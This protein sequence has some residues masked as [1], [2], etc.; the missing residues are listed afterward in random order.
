MSETEAETSPLP[1]GGTVRPI[2]RWGE[3]VMHRVQEPVTEFDDDLRALAADMVATMYAADG[4]GLVGSDVPALLAH[5]RDVIPLDNRQVAEVRAGSVRLFDFE[6]NEVEPRTVTI[7]WDLEAAEKGGFED[8]MLKEI[9]EQPE[10]VR[11]TMLGRIDSNGRVTLD[12]VHWTNGE[13]REIDK[14]VMLK[15]LGSSDG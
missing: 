13:L 3:H 2:T 6:G 8:F 15:R 12:E 9:H 4:V 1:Q 7:D 10:A 14:I 5:T 11:N